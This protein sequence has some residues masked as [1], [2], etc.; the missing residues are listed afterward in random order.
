MKQNLLFRKIGI[1][2]FVL[3]L[4]ISNL[5]YSQKKITG[6]VSDK[7]TNEGLPGTTVQ[8]KGQ[9]KGTSTDV[10]GNY[11][12]EAKSEDVLVF[13]S[14]GYNSKEITVGNQTVINLALE[15]DSRALSEVIVTGYGQQSKRDITGAV[16]TVNMKDVLAVPAT[17]LAQAIQGRVAGVNVGTDNSPGGGV[18]VRIRGFGTVN[19]NSP[20]YIIDGTPTKGNLNTLNL[21]DIESMQ[22][23]KDASAASIY[24][25]RAGNGVVII[26][27]KRG[28][29]GK[30]KF[31]YDTYFAMQAPRKGFEL[32]N[33]QEYLDTFWRS[34]INANN[35]LVNGVA[36]PNAGATT[37]RYPSSVHFGNGASPVMPDYI[38]KS[39][40]VNEGSP[41][42]D[43]S[44]YVRDLLNPGTRNLI[45]KTNKIGTN[46]FD[47]A[48]QPA[49][50]QNHQI[51]VS[52]ATESARYSLSL[53]YF[54]Q[55]GIMKYTG[56]KRYAL[57]TNTEFNINKRVRIGENVQISYDETV[58]QRNGNQTENNPISFIYRQ[59][60]FIPVYDI[61]GNWGGTFSAGLDNSRNPIADLY[62]QKDNVLK[63]ARFFGNAYAEV[64]ILKN[65]T[66][67]SQ[68]GMDYNQFNVRN[69]FPVDIQNA[70]NAA[71][72]SF[73]QTNAFEWT[74]TW[75][76]T[77][78]YKKSFLDNKLNLNVI[79]GV[80]SIKS[81]NEF[82]TAGRL[83]FASDDLENR[84]LDAGNA[85]T[86]TNSGAANNWNLASE[87]AKTNLNF[88]DK[89]LVDLTVRRDRSSRFAKEFRS[90]VFPAV[91]LGWRLSN[92]SFMKYISWISD[93]KLR[94]AYGETG[95]QEIGNY[96]S[97]AIFGT[98][99]VQNF[100]DLGGTRSSSLQ[101]YDRTQ[102]RNVNAKWETTR[103][104]DYGFDASLFKG[105]LDV[106][107][108]W[109]NRTT[110]D[111]LFPVE[112]QR[113]QGFA[114]S[115]F[116]NIGEM[117]N[118]GIEL[119]LN[120]DGKVLNNQLTYSIGAQFAT[121]KNEVLKTD[122]NPSTQYFGF[123]TR[124]PAMSVTQQGYPIASFFGY[125]IDGFI[126]TDE[127]GASLPAQFGGG[128]NNKAGNFKFRD[129][130]KDGKISAAD[131]EVI[132]TPHP[133]FTYGINLSL[134]YKA[135]RLDMFG[136]GVQGNQ[137]FNYVRYWTDFPTFAGNR[138]TR[139][140]YESWEPG[141]KD[142][143]LPILRS[144]DNISS[145]PS[146]YYLE[147]GSYF[148]L[149]NI[150]LNYSIPQNL[151]KKVGLSSATIYL[152]GQNL[153]TATKYTGI[154]PEINLRNSTAGTTG[155][156]R[157]IGVDEGAYPTYKAKVIGL[158]LSF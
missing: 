28:K 136:Q 70:E 130:N 137:I 12:L 37:L 103:S 3:C 133:D 77:L 147:D 146:T 79:G 105:A 78:T 21:N 55:P 123:T 66:G 118:K 112:V 73:T 6:K 43:P 49:L 14:I 98:N 7:D 17:N 69:F 76:N 63:N 9:S 15:A 142:P 81:Y 67:R 153:L 108:D 32:A 44:V 40:G 145:S 121:Y 22:V 148:R 71:N 8:I 20:L 39:G 119:G 83:R 64:D 72:N 2:L 144:N 84:Y 1:F 25:S 149:K 120:H 59:Q 122:G 27:T 101:G 68:F 54:D 97:F 156:D 152:Q 31:T 60:P 140:V 33:S 111:M 128:I 19:D 23:L 48:F 96:N 87:F 74:W 52:G 24:G 65:L 41:L 51:G 106:N 18:M 110:S 35:T 80:E 125:R 131:R 135:F 85:G 109:F 139:M 150:Q 91:S 61:M 92:E 134:G 30:P 95:N 151:L 4:L 104:I 90:A 47:E 129:V 126:E 38:V 116:Q 34:F 16:A 124:L 46:W 100:Y 94:A 50:M 86:Q 127:M 10:N 155:Q 82:F 99:V 93:L 102:F 141:K 26:T 36:T 158:N 56:Y 5:G 138:S 157:H 57:R 114:S 113:S 107:F 89:Y 117:R 115:P 11:S 88:K 42:A 143:K 53:N 75:Y 45:Q 13:S 29:V 132:G 154:D 62:T 58:Q